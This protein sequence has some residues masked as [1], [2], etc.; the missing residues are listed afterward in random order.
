MRPLESDVLQFIHDQFPTEAFDQVVDALGCD[1]LSTPHVQRAVLYLSGGSL[2]MLRHY[3]ALARQDLAGL[4]E[5]AE[6]V[7]EAA[8][9]PLEVREFVEPLQPQ[10][11]RAAS[12]D[13]APRGRAGPMR[14][15]RNRKQIRFRLS[16]EQ[17]KGERFYLGT[18]R[19]LVIG[20]PDENL[21]VPCVR[22]SGNVISLMHLP[23]LFVA[24]QICEHI[25]LADVGG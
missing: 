5:R 24:E 19:Y 2:A 20:E 16:A 12:Q 13:P 8:P 11:A 23:L 10:D 18:A 15:P 9:A 4:I 1:A 25:D 21:L 7:L 3:A 6:Y 14:A 17:V 22:R